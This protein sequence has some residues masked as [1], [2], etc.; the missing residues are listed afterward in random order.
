MKVLINWTQKDD[1]TW[2]GHSDGNRFTRPADKSSVTCRTPR[3]GYG[4]GWSS[5]VAL[6]LALADE[7]SPNIKLTD[8]LVVIDLGDIKAIAEDEAD[9][10]G[11]FTQ[12]EGLKF[13]INPEVLAGFRNYLKP[14][15]IRQAA[16]V[17][18]IGTGT[19]HKLKHTIEA[20]NDGY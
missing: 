8:R 19:A 1:Q 17:L 7:E 3:G 15:S 10:I 5:E 16:E 4:H 14:M 6:E 11:F 9:A 20:M 12:V 13:I 2:V 18:C